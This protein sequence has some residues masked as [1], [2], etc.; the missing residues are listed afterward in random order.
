MKNYVKIWVW[1]ILSMLSVWFAW[2]ALLKWDISFDD[3]KQTSNEEAQ[4]I[5]KNLNELFE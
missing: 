1:I 2:Y 3:F 5:D 4:T